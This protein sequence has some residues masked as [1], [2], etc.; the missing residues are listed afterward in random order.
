MVEV[1]RTSVSAKIAHGNATFSL[2]KPK[3][4]PIQ[5][6]ANYHGHKKYIGKASFGGNKNRPQASYHHVTTR[7]WPNQELGRK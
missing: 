7:F 3:W 4:M 1:F 6:V 5:M 2:G